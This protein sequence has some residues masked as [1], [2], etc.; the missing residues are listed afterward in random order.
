[1]PAKADIFESMTPSAPFTVIQKFHLIESC[2]YGSA[3]FVGGTSS[4]ACRRHLP[5]ATLDLRSS[6]EGFM[7]AEFKITD[8]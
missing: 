6:A 2:H 3:Y 1:M 5:L 8:T 7:S 4:V